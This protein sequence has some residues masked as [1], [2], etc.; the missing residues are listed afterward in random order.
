MKLTILFVLIG[1]CLG[2]CQSKLHRQVSNDESNINNEINTEAI[3]QQKFETLMNEDTSDGKS[4]TFTDLIQRQHDFYY[5]AQD[6]VTAFDAE[7]DRLYQL[8]KSGQEISETDTENLQKHRAQLKTAWSFS[9]KNLHETLDV[10]ELVV[11]NANDPASKFA[12][13]SK[14]ILSK[15][16]KWLDNRTKFSNPVALLSLAQHLKDVN[17]DFKQQNSKFQTADFTNSL[18]VTDKFLNSTR[19]NI[20]IKNQILQA[21]KANSPFNS[22][23]SKEWDNYKLQNEKYNLEDDGR[24]PQVLDVLE[25]AS[26]G[27]G[28]VSGNRFPPNT[29]ALTFDDGPHPS[30]TREMYNVLNTNGVHGTFL[31]LSKNILLYPDIVNEAGQ[32][33]FSRGSHSYTHPQLPK[34]GPKGL[35]KEVTIAGQD[36]AKVVGQQPTLFRCPYGDCGGSKSVVRELIAKNNMLHIGWN[37]DTLDWQDK[38][39]LSIFERAKKQIALLDHGIIL[40]HDIHPQ[41]VEALKILIPYMKNIKQNQIRPLKEIISVVREKAYESP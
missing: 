22:S 6:L 31:W 39:P 12:A 21:Q 33:G 29:W 20:S 23:T 26:N 35:N 32:Y 11:Q 36:F 19:K 5:I 38:N 9:D 13:N 10:Y 1:L 34:L 2:G 8:K 3:A 16:P 17:V 7:L 24:S 30:H 27:K 28:H 4:H 25:P 14:V 37:V 18:K 41:S 15:L 40:F